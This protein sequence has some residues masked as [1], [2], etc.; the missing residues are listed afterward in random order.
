MT[1]LMGLST[2]SDGALQ[3]LANTVADGDL[4]LLADNINDLFASVSSDLPPIG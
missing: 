3:G 2:G 4:Q 1:S